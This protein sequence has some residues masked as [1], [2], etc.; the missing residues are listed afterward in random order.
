MLFRSKQQDDAIYK[1]RNAAIEQ[2]RIVKE[3]ELNTEI[4]IAEK[5]KQKREKEME[6][7]RLVQEKQAELDAKK[8]SN[9]IALEEENRRLVELQTENE[10]KKSD[11]RAYDSQALLKT[12]MGVDREIVKA[13][14]TSGMDSKALIAKAFVE[15]GDKAD[16]IGTLNVSPDLLETLT[17]G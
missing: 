16:K 8:L 10:K 4:K 7:K 5:Q 1:R 12:F 3:N 14:A 15:I 6:T 11:A 13:L 9:D 2:E 17:R